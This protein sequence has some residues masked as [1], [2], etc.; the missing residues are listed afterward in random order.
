MGHLGKPLSLTYDK[1]CFFPF[2][3]LIPPRNNFFVV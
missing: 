3:T 1:F 2:I